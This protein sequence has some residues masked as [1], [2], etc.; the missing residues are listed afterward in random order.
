MIHMLLTIVTI[1]ENTFINIM[2]ILRDYFI[3][4]LEVA[5]RIPNVDGMKQ[6]LTLV[7]QI[8]LTVLRVMIC[9]LPRSRLISVIDNDTN[10]QTHF[11]SSMYILKTRR[12]HNLLPKDMNT[13]D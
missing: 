7:P 4:K 5:G 13:I 6:W 11:V 2:A 3:L 12:R 8:D 1:F 10:H 9:L